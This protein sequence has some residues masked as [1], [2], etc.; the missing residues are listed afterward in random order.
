[1]SDEQLNKGKAMLEAVA[2]DYARGHGLTPE[3]EW[4][5]QGLEW[6]LRLEDDQHTVR[7]MFS[8]DEIEFFVEDDPL[9]RET[10][11]KIRNAFASLS[12]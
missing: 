9:N 10:K 4:V 6:M 12:M 11:M 3:A 5:N 7:L 2:L 8:S 1:M